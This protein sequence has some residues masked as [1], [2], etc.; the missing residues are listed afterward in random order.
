MPSSPEAICFFRLTRKKRQWLVV[1]A[2]IV[3]A[4]GQVCGVCPPFVLNVEEAANARF[5]MA[6]AN[7]PIVVTKGL[8][9]GEFPPFAPNVAE[10]VSALPVKCVKKT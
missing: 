1:S 3:M 9:C 8:V 6:A 2:P 7:A 5:V 10:V 4:K